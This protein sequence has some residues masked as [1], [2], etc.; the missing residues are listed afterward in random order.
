MDTVAIDERLVQYIVYQLRKEHY[1]GHSDELGQH[2]LVERKVKVEDNTDGQAEKDADERADVGYDIE[3]P[4]NEPDDNCVAEVQTDDGKPEYVERH[5]S[6]DL[7][8]QADK[9]AHEKPLYGVEGIVRLFFVARRNYRHDHAG[10]ETAVFEEEEGYEGDGEKGDA[11]VAYYPGQAAE[12]GTEARNVY[13]FANGV[14]YV[15][16]DVFAFIHEAV[17]FQETSGFFDR[18]LQLGNYFADTDVFQGLE[19][20][21]SQRYDGT[22]EED[23]QQPQQGDG[24]S[25]LKGIGKGIVAYFN[26][27]QEV[28]DGLANE[29][30]NGSDQDVDDDGEEVPRE[31]NCDEQG[32]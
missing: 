16:V 1:G 3:D 18:F 15:G 6:D 22:K 30:D 27:P 9:V 21:Y 17:V 23:E 11:E 12:P 20:V 13:P 32:N 29:G 28:D 24:G 25:R 31:E 8:K 14:R 10:K 7:Q 2:F 5:D 19:F 4:R 26:A